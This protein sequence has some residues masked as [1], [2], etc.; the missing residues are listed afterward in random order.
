MD[1][2]AFVDFG[3]LQVRSKHR[4]VTLSVNMTLLQWGVEVFLHG[5]GR[6][7]QGINIFPSDFLTLEESTKRLQ[8]YHRE[9]I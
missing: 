4:L 7:S 8:F 2:T 5:S 9:L 6:K 3:I 1:T